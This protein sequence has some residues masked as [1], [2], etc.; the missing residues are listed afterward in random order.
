MGYQEF[1]EDLLEKDE[2]IEIGEMG[3]EA[4]NGELI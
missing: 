3:E 1:D 2:R 4:M